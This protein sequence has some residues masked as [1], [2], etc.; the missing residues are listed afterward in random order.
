MM[1]SLHVWAKKKNRILCNTQP[2]RHDFTFFNPYNNFLFIAISTA[3]IITFCAS[4]TLVDSEFAENV[5]FRTKCIWTLFFRLIS[6]ID[7]LYPYPY[8]WLF[9]LC[10][11]YVFTWWQRQSQDVCLCM[12]S[13]LNVKVGQ[14][15][16]DGG[17][18][19]ALPMS[20]F[21]ISEQAKD[22]AAG[23]HNS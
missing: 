9:A 6:F 12:F 20:M 19:T 5:W 2:S 8:F 21:L 15:R 7:I 17:W 3:W 18:L 13:A 22:V 14:W 16:V 4:V 11:F 1:R 23:Q 10:I